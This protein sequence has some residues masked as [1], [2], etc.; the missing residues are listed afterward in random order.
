MTF[1]EQMAINKAKSQF[2]QFKKNKTAFVQS[3]ANLVNHF[4]NLIKKGTVIDAGSVK[5]QF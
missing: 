1:E 5:I 2:K 4:M 3:R